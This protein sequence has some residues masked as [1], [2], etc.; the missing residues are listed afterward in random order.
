MSSAT[1]HADIRA[2]CRS[3]LQQLA[4]LP[5]GRAWEG[6]SF[7]PKRG[8]PFFAD[9]LA[10]IHSSPRSIGAIEHGMTYTVT[11]KFPADRGTGEIEALA[12]KL[13]DHFRVG[14]QLVS[15]ASSALCTKAEIRGG[16]QQDIDWVALPVV[17]HLTAFT[18]D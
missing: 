11:L 16:V 15:G 6:F 8:Q 18:T 5:A 2:A 9:R 12:G 17:V 14:T 4:D 13:L 7:T 1:V 10:A 3:R